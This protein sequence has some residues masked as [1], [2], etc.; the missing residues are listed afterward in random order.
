MLIGCTEYTHLTKRYQLSGPAND[1]RLTAE[2]LNERFGFS[3][4]Q[5]VSLTHENSPELQPTRENIVRE[6]DNLVAGV[7]DGEIVFILLAGHGCREPDDESDDPADVEEDGWDEVFLPQDITTWHTKAPVVKGIADDQ[8]R[9]WLDAIRKKGAFVLFM[10]DTCHSGTMD[11]GPAD[12]AGLVRYRIVE[13]SVISS[14]QLLERAIVREHPP[15]TAPAGDDEP[16]ADDFLGIVDSGGATSGGLVALY[17]VPANSAEAEQPPPDGSADQSYGRLSYAVNQILRRVVRPITYRELAQ[18]LHWWYEQWQWYPVGSIHGADLDREVLG[19]GV[20]QDRSAVIMTRNADNSL[21]LNVGSLR[22][23]TKNSIFAVYPPIGESQDEQLAGYV[24]VVETTPVAAEVEPCEYNGRHVA[25]ADQFPRR[26]RCELAYAAFDL[27]LAVGVA[28]FDPNRRD[29][30]ALA[31]IRSAVEHIAQQNGA[32][33]RLAGTDEN[34]EV[35]VLADNDGV[36]LRRPH[37]ITRRITERGPEIVSQTDET[38]SRLFGPIKREAEWQNRLNTSLSTMG[39]AINL[40]KL[41]SDD[42]ESLAGDP[43]DPKV[44]LDLVVKKWNTQSRSFETEFNR[45]T[46]T[47]TDRDKIRVEVSNVGSVPVDVTVLY[48]ESAYRIISYF[49]TL[50]DAM[51][52]HLN[53]RLEPD[54]RPKIVQFTI[55]DRTVGKEDVVVIGVAADPSLPPQNFAFLEQEGLEEARAADVQTRGA[56]NSA[57]K[58]PLG[59]LVC[60]A[61]Y[62]EGTRGGAEPIEI[63]DYAIRRISWLVRKRDAAA[64]RDGQ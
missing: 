8:F 32:L 17:A 14:P 39:R 44:E 31:Q 63:S 12:D 21:T 47:L 33:V 50:P 40:R 53:N 9:T 64:T 52:G 30:A 62:G 20:W 3:D 10:A 54:G 15:D 24:K 37:D 5:I 7:R 51:S 27:K 43:F 42:K 11:R 35:Y 45:S 59:E 57:F 22:G 36:Y 6:F 49:P 56:G 23:V 60:S 46:L 19:R 16:A 29:E 13:P 28:P 58:S 4:E 18:R 41:V 25:P 48:V 38:P 1:V 2:L 34:A 55:N 61:I 26:A